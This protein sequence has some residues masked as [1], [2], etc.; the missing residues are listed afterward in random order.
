MKTGR[1]VV[2][3]LAVQLRRVRISAMTAVVEI[4]KSKFWDMFQWQSLQGLLI[5]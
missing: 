3:Q 2:L 1:L 5:D 4:E